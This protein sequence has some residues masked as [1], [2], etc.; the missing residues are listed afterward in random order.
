MSAPKTYVP[1]SKAKV[2]PTQYGDMMKLGF[3]ASTLIE[4]IKANTNNAGYFNLTV[5][6][7]REPDQ[8]GNTHSICLDTW[9]PNGDRKPP[10]NQPALPK[11]DAPT[12]NDNV[13]F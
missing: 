8:Y 2:I 4:F 13:P 12:E 3:H 7:R 10:T 6:E 9:V 5:S 1:K 11:T